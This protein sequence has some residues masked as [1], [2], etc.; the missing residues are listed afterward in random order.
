VQ[1]P[2]SP[3][4]P[5]S[6]IHRHTECAGAAICRLTGVPKRDSD[7]AHAQPKILVALDVVDLEVADLLMH[8]EGLSGDSR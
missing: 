1:P 5:S 4:G 3:Q 2:A 6:A 7:V 8:P